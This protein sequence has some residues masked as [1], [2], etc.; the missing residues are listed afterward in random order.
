MKRDSQM[1]TLDV[2][3]TAWTQ[4][5]GASGIPRA[6]KRRLSAFIGGFKAL[7]WNWG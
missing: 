5:S 4:G 3:A 6:W 2:W 7:L 1:K